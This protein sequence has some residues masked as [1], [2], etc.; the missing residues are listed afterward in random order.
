MRVV[1]RNL[2]IPF[3]GE[4]RNRLNPDGIFVFM[5]YKKDWFLPLNDRFKRRFKVVENG[6]WEWQGFTND[7]GYGKIVSN[8]KCLFAHRVSYEIYNG[9]IPDKLLVCH[10]CDNPICVNPKHLFLGTHKDNSQ[11]ASKKGRLK[12]VDH[13]NT[14][15]FK[16]GCRC[17]ECVAFMKNR[18]KIKTANTTE[19]RK[20]KY[21]ENREEMLQRGREFYSKNRER[22]KEKQ[23]KYN[24]ENREKINERQRAYHAKKR[25]NQN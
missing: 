24:K 15:T 20:R 23:D 12:K 10:S 16:N 3:G 17:A 11:D 9:P 4:C 14:F 2:I 5:D 19:E 6:C 25:L 18:N 8:K 1:I 22:L 7:N 21:H 13:P